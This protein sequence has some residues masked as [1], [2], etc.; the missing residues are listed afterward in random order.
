MFKWVPSWRQEFSNN[1][2]RD[3]QREMYNRDSTAFWVYRIRKGCVHAP[4][5]IWRTS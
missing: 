2:F 4:V 1:Q 3:S 5:V